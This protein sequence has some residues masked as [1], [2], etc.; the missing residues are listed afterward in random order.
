MS[1]REIPLT[2]GYVA[3]VDDADFEW[4]N[5][6]KWYFR[7]HDCSVGIAVR[8][9]RKD[10]ADGSSHVRMHRALL[11]VTDRRVLVDH[12]NHNTLD[13]RRENLRVCTPRQNLGNQLS[14]PGSSVYKGVC[15]KKRQ[16]RWHSQITTPR[17]NRHLGYFVDEEDAAQA[18]DVAAVEVFGEFAL[19]NFPGERSSA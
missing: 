3:L 7:P 9:R 10:D 12:I 14:R 11:G 8:N 6:W 16:R 19:L 13:N 15:W 5:Q 18:Y 4:L 2:R 1:I 17:G